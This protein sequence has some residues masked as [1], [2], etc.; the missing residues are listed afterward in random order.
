MFE[1]SVSIAPQVRRLPHDAGAIRA[2]RALFAKARAARRA[3]HLD[4]MGR[5]RALIER[6]RRLLEAS[7]PAAPF[8]PPAPAPVRTSPHDVP[9]FGPADLRRLAAQARHFAESLPPEDRRLLSARAA[10]LEQDA[11]RLESH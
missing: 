8:S 7:D 5:T 1:P 4:R 2:L 11:A 3:D 6:S 9:Y 10:R